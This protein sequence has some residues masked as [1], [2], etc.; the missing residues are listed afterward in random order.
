MN[1][2]QYIS[3]YSMANSASKLQLI[4]QRWILVLSYDGSR[5]FGWQKQAEGIPTVQA[6]LESAISKIAGENI[7]VTV[8]G[9]TD[10][11]VHAIAQVVHFDTGVFRPPQE[12]ISS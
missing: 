8:A 7:S 5:F 9:R 6:E 3:D 10:T 2:S 11:G 4:K 12:C 1:F